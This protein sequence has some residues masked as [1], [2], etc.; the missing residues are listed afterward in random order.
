M[1]KAT[2]GENLLG[3]LLVHKE[4]SGLLKLPDFAKM[5]S[6]HE[7]TTWTFIEEFIGK[8]KS[9]PTHETVELET[10]TVLPEPVEVPSY[11][12]EHLRKRWVSEKIK[13]AIAEAKSH[14]PMTKE[15]DPDAAY[16]AM[17]NVMM[18]VVQT[19]NYGKLFDARY[20][21]EPVMMEHKKG[22]GYEEGIEFGWPYLDHHCGG[23][24]SGD[25]VSYVGRPAH[26]K[27]WQLLW[28]ARHAWLQQQ[29]RVM[30]VSMEMEPVQILTRLA[31]LESHIE[32]KIIKAGHL[33]TFQKAKVEGLS[34]LEQAETPFWVI[35]GNLSATT[36][37]IQLM[38][39]TL[40]PDVIYI[41]G[42]YLVRHPDPKLN[43]YARV[44]TVCEQ[45]KMDLAG[46]LGVPVVAS[47][48]FNR[49]AAKKKDDDK[50]GLED[51]AYSDVIGQL[52]SIV[53]GL[54][55]GGTVE[56][57]ETKRIDLLKGRG[58]EEGE[59]HTKWDFKSMDFSQVS[60]P[61]APSSESA[62]TVDD[63]EHDDDTL[64]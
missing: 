19:N 5:L 23:L 20:L 41:D 38:A 33:S 9:F 27:T 58:G 46:G 1:A 11:Y 55:E 54:F 59:F 26:G 30:F 48:Q 29:K 62:V 34:Y 2:V 22:L 16:D 10:S 53:L 47:W 45:I 24:R 56:Q 6:E 61:G 12:A 8:H 64:T 57:E 13:E 37:D 44:A 49:Q 7:A 52:S 43:Q 35:D 50:I 25:L 21:V 60:A 42:A 14:L 3:A 15:A 36:Q 32:N 51:I 4:L 28:S 40:N 63:L 39:R 18:D 17:M 31:A